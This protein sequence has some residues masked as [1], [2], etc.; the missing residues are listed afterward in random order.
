M[1]VVDVVFFSVI[2][3]CIGLLLGVGFMWNLIPKWINVK[4]KKPD[5]YQSVL[6]YVQ[7]TEKWRGNTPPEE[8]WHVIEEDCWLGDRWDCNAD[9]DVHEIT[10]WQPKPKAP[11]RGGYTCMSGKAKLRALCVMIIGLSCSCLVYT[12]GSSEPIVSSPI[13]ALAP[14]I[15]GLVLYSLVED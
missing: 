15:I 7:H 2:S 8:Q 3:G 6:V 9:D 10:H 5:P 13:I 14:L 4:Y 1:T 12:L 11:Y